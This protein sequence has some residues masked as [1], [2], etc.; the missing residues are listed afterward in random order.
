MKFPWYGLIHPALAVFTLGYG[1]R[2]AQIALS[3]INDWD[4]PLRQQRNRTIT[5]LLLCV[6]NFVT[7]MFFATIIRGRGLELKL[8]G[9]LVL[10]VIVLGVTALATVV[11]F[12]RS[13]MGEVAPITRLHP[14]LMVI[15]LTGVLT[16]GI[17]TLLRVFG[18]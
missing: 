11:T 16:Q 6:G 7:G 4:Y 5:Y 17:L 9:H 10:S 13:R 1:L 3:R 12:G 14:I 18:I 2:I 8:P 15:S